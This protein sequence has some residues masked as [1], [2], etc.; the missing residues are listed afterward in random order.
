MEQLCPEY[1]LHLFKPIVTDAL[2]PPPTVT[3]PGSCF[4][5]SDL[6]L[7][8]ADL[9]FLLG[10]DWLVV[11]PDPCVA[12]TTFLTTVDSPELTPFLPPPGNVVEE[13]FVLPFFPGFGLGGLA[14]LVEGSLESE[15][16]SDSA[17]D[18]NSASAAVL[19]LAFGDVVAVVD[20]DTEA[21]PFW[22]ERG[23]LP[24]SHSFLWI[25]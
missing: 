20:D 7:P 1:N 15:S 10:V 9:K 14:L 13:P 12:P 16:D 23:L 4:H 6:P 5:H 21:V 3:P 17:S 2:A 19:F 22:A 18:A 24:F 11:D 25:R 8:P